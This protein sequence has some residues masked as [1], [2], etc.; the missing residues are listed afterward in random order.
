MT[1]SSERL[2]LSPALGEHLAGVS[3]VT[4]T[5]F[6]SD[7]RLD[8]ASMARLVAHI[9]Q[10]GV[11][12][13]TI[14]G[15]VGEFMSLTSDELL[16]VLRVTIATA[17]AT[18]VLAATGLDCRTAIEGA[19]AALAL[20]AAGIMIHQPL[21]PLRS[22]DGWVAYQR[23]IADALSPAPIVLYISDTNIGVRVVASLAE[24]CPNVLAAKYAV[25][26]PPRLAMLTAA[27][28]DRLTWLCGLAERWAPSFWTAGC[29]GFTSG[30]ANV[31]PGIALEML[32]SL[33]ASDHAEQARIWRLI[34]GFEALQ[35]DRGGGASVGVVKAALVARGLIAREHVRPPLGPLSS[36]EADEVGTVIAD[37][38]VR[39]AARG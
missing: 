5:P 8:T 33:R 19:E 28:G 17:E 23:E 15:S 7:G 11:H 12:T 29:R 35:A 24:K 22:L 4:V 34:A 31:F 18:P 20:G 38:E 2:R 16:E 39:G 36:A 10:G 26:D 14:G 13:I 9:G 27:L 25:P 3:A 1:M 37:W 30:I 21:N 32:S 6:D